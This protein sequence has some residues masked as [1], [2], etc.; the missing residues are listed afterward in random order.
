MESGFKPN[1]MH[2][3]PDASTYCKLNPLVSYIPATL[4]SES[5]DRIIT[6]LL[7]QGAIQQT[8]IGDLRAQA[9][10]QRAAVAGALQRVDACCGRVA[11][12]EDQARGLLATV[13]SLAREL[14]AGLASAA[15][16]AARNH[17]EHS[18]QLAAAATRVAAVEEKVDGLESAHADA[19][20]RVKTLETTVEDGM[21]KTEAALDDSARRLAAQKKLGFAVEE[22]C[23]LLEGSIGGLRASCDSAMRGVAE[24][25]AG[26]AAEALARADLRSEV[27]LLDGRRGAA[28]DAL[29]ED[30]QELTADLAAR[31][32]AQTEK[33]DR[34]E[35]HFEERWVKVDS[36]CHQVSLQPGH[37]GF[38]DEGEE[39][40]S[41]VLS[42]LGGKIS[43][44]L[45][46]LVLFE[47]KVNQHEEGL[48][49]VEDHLI[50]ALRGARGGDATHRRLSRPVDSGFVSKKHGKAGPLPQRAEAAGCEM[51]AADVL[52]QTK[53][54]IKCLSCNAR[55]TAPRNSEGAKHRMDMEGT[56]PGSVLHASP[57]GHPPPLR[58]GRP[59]SAD[60]VTSVPAVHTPVIA[61]S[62]PSPIGITPPAFKPNAPPLQVFIEPRPPARKP[63]TE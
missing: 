48:S 32:D 62:V 55:K 26:L 45:S 13:D 54:L 8:Q 17:A 28:V 39:P 9:E 19:K 11:A 22:R 14:A 23:E 5:L 30:F 38:V 47:S 33:M 12:A 42:L 4:S 29:R 63:A 61:G 53:Q 21:A 44:I 37:A 16:A 6:H 41:S 59:T 40:A 52:L 34:L 10:E 25:K 36:L 43:D 58:K 49:R 18:G 3:A 1:L 7:S 20:A 51:H 15:A 50:S 46:L 2:P 57:M 35:V 60:K 56:L 27:A 24:L 31:T